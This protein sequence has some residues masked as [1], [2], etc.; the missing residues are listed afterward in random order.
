MLR[1]SLGRLSEFSRWNKGRY[2]RGERDGNLNKSTFFEFRS[3]LVVPWF[4]FGSSL[5]FSPRGI[6]KVQREGILRKV[7]FEL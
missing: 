4:F 7:L 5:V 1:S 6:G 3:S 2:K